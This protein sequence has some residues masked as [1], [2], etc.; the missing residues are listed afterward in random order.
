MSIPIWKILICNL[1]FLKLRIMIYIIDTEVSYPLNYP[2]S[3]DLV[4]RNP[5]GGVV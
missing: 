5:K 4:R 2:A 3:A 1:A